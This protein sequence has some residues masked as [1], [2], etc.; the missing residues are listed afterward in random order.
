MSR[1]Y[2]AC[3]NKADL[4]F[5]DDNQRWLCTALPTL[6]N[7]GGWMTRCTAEF[8]FSP[9]GWDTYEFYT[10][11][12]WNTPAIIQQN[13]LNALYQRGTFSNSQTKLIPSPYPARPANADQDGGG[14]GVGR[15]P[16]QL[17]RPMNALVGFVSQGIF[18]P[19]SD[20]AT[21]LTDVAALNIYDKVDTGSGSIGGTVGVA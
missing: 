7:D 2:V 11:P 18:A 9:Y 13:I 12:L 10:D 3:T 21:A 20:L 19:P 8:V 1:L 15:F 5:K 6:S 14:T 4:F 17:C 16:Q